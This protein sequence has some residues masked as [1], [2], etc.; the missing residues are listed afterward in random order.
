MCRA[1]PHRRGDHVDPEQEVRREL[2]QQVDS[3]GCP[4]FQALGAEVFHWPQ[5]KEWPR[6]EG[7][8]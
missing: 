5:G 4:V 8:P 2:E 6:G 7:G 1:T 3:T